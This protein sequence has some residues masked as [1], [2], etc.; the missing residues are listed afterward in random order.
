MVGNHSGNDYWK[1]F[2]ERTEGLDGRQKGKSVIVDPARTFDKHMQLET[3]R[4]II[5]KFRPSDAVFILKL[6]NEP[7][8]HANIG[9]K[10]IRDEND[11]LAYIRKSGSES[12]ARL[13]FEMYL[14]AL[15]D[16]GASIGIC[17]LLQ[18]EF[19]PH[20]DLGFAYASE[21]WNKG[22]GTE[23][24]KAVISWATTTLGHSKLS[25]FTSTANG[26]SLQ[27]LKKSGFVSLGEQILP[28]REEKSHVLL[29]HAPA[30]KT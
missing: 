25:A 9:D 27:L 10:N 20:P 29:W 23:A 15:K 6:V 24:A 8:F 18:R 28:G 1:L 11:A 12:Y 7:A 13:G 5:R 26:A 19:L 4:L 17:G 21:F 14:V 3:E 22:Y 30:E 2:R 16:S